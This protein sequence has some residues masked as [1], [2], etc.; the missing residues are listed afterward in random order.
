[1]YEMKITILWTKYLAWFCL[2]T[3]LLSLSCLTFGQTSTC[4][5]TYHYV[6]KK[7]QG[8]S[9]IN[10]LST[11]SFDSK[12]EE[13]YKSFKHE[14]SGSQIFVGVHIFGGTK[15]DPKRHWETA[16][17]VGDKKIDGDDIFGYADSSVAGSE[18][19]RKGNYLTVGRT[20]ETKD[21]IYRFQFGCVRDN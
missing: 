5:L 16:I 14:E 10:L 19:G 21:R 6:E 9:S 17:A 1:M 3:W 7:P 13:N 8:F 12:E 18:F 4:R 2:I 20:I 15:T 11:F